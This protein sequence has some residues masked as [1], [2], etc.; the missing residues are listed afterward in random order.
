MVLESGH[1]AVRMCEE[2]VT[3][4]TWRLW[5]TENAMM[6]ITRP[7]RLVVYLSRVLGELVC[8]TGGLLCVVHG[9]DC[10]RRRG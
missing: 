2:R 9:I 6:R 5:R 7:W 4:G 10:G 1:A 8:D 3:S